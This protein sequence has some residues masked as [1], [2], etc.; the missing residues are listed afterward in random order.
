MEKGKDI[1]K[2]PTQGTASEKI[3]VTVADAVASVG[4]K[5][6]SRNSVVLCGFVAEGSLRGRKPSE[7][8]SCRGVSLE[9]LPP[10][11]QR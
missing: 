9:K 1:V 3:H 5:N 2:F 4:A 11:P 10:H 7:L 8:T 6:F